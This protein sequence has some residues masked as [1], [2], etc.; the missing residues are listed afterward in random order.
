MWVTFI[1]V[2]SSPWQAASALTC[3]AIFTISRLQE[4]SPRHE[5]RS[6]AYV[7]MYLDNISTLIS[8]LTQGGSVTKALVFTMEASIHARNEHVIST[9]DGTN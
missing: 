4:A 3:N 7:A 1:L 6:N 2:A 9:V 5:W 8:S